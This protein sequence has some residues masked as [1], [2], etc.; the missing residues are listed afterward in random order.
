MSLS[1]LA[2]VIKWDESP[3]LFSAFLFL[4]FLD[5]DD[6]DEDFFGFAEGFSKDAASAEGM[7]ISTG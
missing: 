7:G 3:V 2:G 4:L 6:V 1:F 5:K